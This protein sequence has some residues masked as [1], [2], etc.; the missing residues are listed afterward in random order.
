[1]SLRRLCPAVLAAL[2]VSSSACAPPQHKLL[3][4]FTE[5]QL[6]AEAASR[7]ERELG[8]SPYSAELHNN[9]AVCYEALGRHEQAL[10]H[11][12]RA[13]ELAPDRADIRGNYEAARRLAGAAPPAGDAS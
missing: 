8:Q 1:V 11:Y 10:E 6:W 4:R 7:F 13:L 5:Q 3:R 2:V 9:L 12:A